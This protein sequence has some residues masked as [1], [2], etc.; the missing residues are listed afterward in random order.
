MSA[1][2]HSGWVPIP[3]H[4]VLTHFPIAFFALELALLT[5]RFV[6]RDPA[7]ERLAEIAFRS[8]YALMLPTMAAGWA[9]AGG[10]PGVQGLARGH[11]LAAAAV[12]VIATLRIPVR[13]AFRG[14][15]EA[16]RVINWAGALVVCAALAWAGYQGGI[17]VH[18]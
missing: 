10:L 8:A 7:Y 5:A 6:R 14:K 4:P 3:L 11:A 17:L 9:D 12:F 2:A 1:A 15:P 16:Y 13:R 18:T